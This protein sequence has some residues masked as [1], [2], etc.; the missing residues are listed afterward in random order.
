[1]A[2][3]L[4]KLVGPCVLSLDVSPCAALKDRPRRTLSPNNGC[5]FVQKVLIRSLGFP[6]RRTEVPLI[7]HRAN[8]DCDGEVDLPTF[9]AIS[10]STF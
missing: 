1:M 4:L 9:R 10:E 3:I 7:V 2:V 6:V 5:N 8:P